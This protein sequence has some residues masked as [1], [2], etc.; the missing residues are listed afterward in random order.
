MNTNEIIWMWLIVLLLCFV[1]TTRPTEWFAFARKY[2]KWTVESL[3]WS[4]YMS[5]LTGPS[6]GKNHNQDTFDFDEKGQDTSQKGK[7]K[8]FPRPRRTT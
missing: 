4:P 3:K 8:I 5:Q 7:S 1:A 6:K 2:F